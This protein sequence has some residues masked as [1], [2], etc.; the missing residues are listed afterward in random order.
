MID[1]Q[2][3]EGPGQSALDRLLEKISAFV[4]LLVVVA[5]AACLLNLVFFYAGR[6]YG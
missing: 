5:G 2:R 4:R 1:K 3:P 6:W